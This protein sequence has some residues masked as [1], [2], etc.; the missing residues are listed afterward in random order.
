MGLGSAQGQA[1]KPLAALTGARMNCQ[2]GLPLSTLLTSFITRY[3]TIVDVLYLQDLMFRFYS[4][5]RTEVL[6]SMEE[7]KSLF[8]HDV[9]RKHN[10]VH[11]S[12]TPSGKTKQTMK[13]LCRHLYRDGVR[14]DN[15]RDREDQAVTL[16]QTQNAPTVQET[17]LLEERQK[18]KSGHPI[19]QI[20]LTSFRGT[21]LHATAAR[22]VR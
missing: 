11:A 12:F 19:L 6:S 4:R 7:M 13:R 2:Q 16:F 3:F 22:G 5:I 20:D 14:A 15:I 18:G 9:S 10:H 21:M 17:K 1:R 8:I